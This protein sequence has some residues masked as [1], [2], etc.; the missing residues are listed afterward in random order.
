MINI[1]NISI[2]KR[3]MFIFAIWII[4]FIGLGIYVLKEMSNLSSIS[5]DICNQPMQVSNAATEVRVDIIKMQKNMKDLILSRDWEE[6][7]KQLDILKSIRRSILDNLDII[8][9]QTRLDS[10]SQMEEEI[11]GNFIEWNSRMEYT[12]SLF[13]SGNKGQALQIL[14][15]ELLTYSN[16]C[17]ELMISISQAEIGK[18]NELLKDAQN[19]EAT[20]RR[21]LT[22]AIALI[23]LIMFIVFIVMI[24]SVLSPIT[25]L[26]NVMDSNIN[27]GKLLTVDIDGNNEITDMSRYYNSMIDKLKKL[28]WAKDCKNLL[29]QEMSGY[30]ILEELSQRIINF[31]CRKLDAAKGV[32]YIL[33]RESNLLKL[34][35]TFAFNEKDKLS[36][37]LSIGEGIVGQ[38][39]LEKKAILLKD[40]K[41]EQETISTAIISEAPL[42]LYAFPLIYEGEL[43]GVIELA[44][45]KLFTKEELEFLNVVSENIAISINSAMQNEQI[46]Y[47]RQ[48]SEDA[49]KAAY[50]KAE[51]LNEANRIMEKQ[52]AAL[53]QQTVE[54]QHQAEE[55]QKTN[56]VLEEQR[57]Q[58][59]N[60]T[61]LLDIQNKKLEV[62]G[63]EL[64]KR[65]EELEV[66][67]KYKSE[68]LA[69]MSHEL[70]TPLNSIILLSRLLLDKGKERLILAD[71]QKIKIIN[72][73]GLELLR[74]I[75]DI[76]DLSK[77]ESGMMNIEK[78][79]FHSS[80][81]TK[82]IGEL[83]GSMA[84]EKGL[85]LFIQDD[86]NE[87]LY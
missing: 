13:D 72:Q 24:N 50:M 86:L 30:I 51:E 18:A 3:L 21:L 41:K 81:L 7:Q 37:C 52:Q 32:F 42:A 64:I 17:E 23:S 25:K 2:R 5:R 34:K 33:D 45:L 59:E 58:L 79:P 40:I 62:S 71:R 14:Q 54:L 20:Q 61:T 48:E 29:N 66:I 26:K 80:Y 15:N 53:Q 8:K 69:N 74:L 83:F 36:S 44:S 55:L 19:I 56:Q 49:R 63:R 57:R 84:K 43:Y 11:R 31:L 10:V 76:L 85:E 68:F 82:E 4:I 38:V 47:L 28:F 46:K 67:N 16:R 87:G 22:T 70:R 12:I 27:T 1:Q 73:S 78:Q 6:E 75:N 39:A 60:Q 9:N 35:A 77:I 65:S